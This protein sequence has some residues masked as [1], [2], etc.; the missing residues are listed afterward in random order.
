MIVKVTKYSSYDVHPVPTKIVYEDALSW[1]KGF[2]P[3]M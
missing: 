1:N 2:K 3:E